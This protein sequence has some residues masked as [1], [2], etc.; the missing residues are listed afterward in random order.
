MAMS[1]R[2]RPVKAKAPPRKRDREATQNKLIKAGLEIFSKHGFDAAT[3]QMVAKKAGVNEA[4][5]SRYF[6]GKSGLLAA[7]LVE[8]IKDKESEKASSLGYPPGE[9]VEEEIYN[10]LLAYFEHDLENRDF[11]RVAISRSA[12]DPKIRKEADKHIL[13]EGHPF[14]AERLLTFQKRGLIPPGVDLMEMS[15]V[16]CTE[17]LGFMFTTCLIGAVKTEDIYS[18]IKVSAKTFALGLQTR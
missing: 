13:V 10:F 6:D 18:L 1:K 11:L 4:L 14:F 17:S 15:R 8:F 5:I 7:I 3:T 9:T 2:T 12:V 16:I